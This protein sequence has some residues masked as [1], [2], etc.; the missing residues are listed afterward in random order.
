MTRQQF[1]SRQVL[2]LASLPITVLLLSHSL[3]LTLSAQTTRNTTG[4]NAVSSAGLSNILATRS[5]TSFGSSGGEISD[6]VLDGLAGQGESIGGGISDP[7]TG[8]NSGRGGRGGSASS[9]PIYKL[10]ST[11]SMSTRSRSTASVGSANGRL[12]SSN[13]VHRAMP[14]RIGSANATS[15]YAGALGM[16]HSASGDDSTI[17][18]A[19]Q[20]NSYS[21]TNAET[22]NLEQDSTVLEGGGE[23]SGLFEMLTPS[24]AC[25]LWCNAAPLDSAPKPAASS[26]GRAGASSG[27]STGSGLS[28]GSDSRGV[29]DRGRITRP[30]YG[31]G[32]YGAL[33]GSR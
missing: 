11:A 27:R 9:G 23:G 19:G 20:V 29:S 26:A 12:A 10:G 18:A 32:R 13:R 21:D 14:A 5:G 4:A 15:I 22:N 25:G 1:S 30:S 31:S 28:G 2:A 17:T 8:G 3:S 24:G 33:S 7:L 16:I 6:G